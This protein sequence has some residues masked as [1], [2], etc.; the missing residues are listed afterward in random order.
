MERELFPLAGKT[1]FCNQSSLYFSKAV[2]TFPSNVATIQ[3]ALDWFFL[4]V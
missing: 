4:L 2:S 1:F 3:P